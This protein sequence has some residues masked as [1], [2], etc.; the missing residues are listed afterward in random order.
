MDRLIGRTVGSYRI[1]K[2]LGS[3]AFGAVYRASHQRLNQPRALKILMPQ[4][5]LDTGRAD[6]ALAAALER[7]QLWA[8]NAAELYSLAVDLARAAR[9]WPAAEP[10]PKT[11]PADLALSVLREAV[12]AGFRD[13][14][15]LR[16][17]PAFAALRKRA[18][19]A[20]LLAGL[21]ADNGPR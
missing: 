12:A 6:E 5:A 11:D 7:Q 1:E 21:A 14:D 4:L 20:E 10:A 17:E 8:G 19:F 18:D 16:K 13:G 15:R 2:L 3:G 9:S